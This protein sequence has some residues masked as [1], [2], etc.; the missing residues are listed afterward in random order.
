MRGRF[1]SVF[2]MIKTG[3]YEVR[4]YL[5]NPMLEIYIT[6]QLFNKV[7]KNKLLG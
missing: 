5:E 3:L 7:S 4:F 6:F 1:I 2:K